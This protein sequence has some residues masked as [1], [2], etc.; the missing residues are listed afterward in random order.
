MRAGQLWHP[1]LVS[2]K[3]SVA[4]LTRTRRRTF[5]T[6][7]AS[8]K[9]LWC[10]GSGRCR[11]AGS[12]PGAVSH[13]VTRGNLWGGG[14]GRLSGSVRHGNQFTTFARFVSD[15]V[16][17]QSGQAQS[18][19]KVRLVRCGQSCS[20]QDCQPVTPR[21]Q[22]FGDRIQLSDST[23]LI[24]F[25]RLAKLIR[26]ASSREPLGGRKCVETERTASEW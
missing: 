2:E 18:R 3:I 16:F 4:V 13:R 20:G 26:I 25:R 21:R 7:I 5:R 8:I 24:I 23:W 19:G 14:N 1:V 10:V 9:L 22:L 12:S 15:T 6:R 17:A 11:K